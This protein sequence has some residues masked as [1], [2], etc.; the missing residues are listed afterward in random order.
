MEELSEAAQQVI[1]RYC[2]EAG[3]GKYA[4]LCAVG[5]TLPWSIPSLADFELL[6]QVARAFAHK[7]IKFMVMLQL[8][9]ALFSCIRISLHLSASIT[10]PQVVVHGISVQCVQVRKAP[11]LS[12]M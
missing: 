8:S 5:A 6:A 12:T 1:K 3:S 11:V 10:G 2:K 4:P 7:C 9:A